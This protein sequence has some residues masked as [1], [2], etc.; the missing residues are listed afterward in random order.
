MTSGANHPHWWDPYSN[1]PYRLSGKRKPR[2]SA[3]SLAEYLKVAGTALAVS[4]RLLWRYATA[5]AAPTDRPAP[6]FIGLSISPDERHSDEIRGMVDELGVEELLIRIPSWDLDRVDEYV[7][8]AS[9]FRD[10]RLLFNILQCRESVMQPGA[11]AAALETI[12]TRFGHL[13]GYFQIG[14]AVNRTKWGC[15]HSGEYLALLEAAERV[16]AAHPGVRLVGSSVIDF[17]PLVTLRTLLNA[18]R[19]HL[20]VVSS[21]MYVN[22]R[23][24]PRGRQYLVFDLLRKLRLLHAI[25]S[26]GNRN[27]RRLWITE[28]NWPLLNTK[29]YTPNSGHP[30]R[31]VDE[32]TQAA[33]MTDYYRIAWQ[34]GWVEKVYWWELISPGYGLVD[35]RDGVL[36][37]LP[38]YYAFKALLEGGL[39][40]PPSAAP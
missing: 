20:D 11:W 2:R 4:P 36:R 37:K 21:L 9:R 28:F 27:D 33:Y 26:I 30:D 5:R 14:N 39:Y 13:S 40:E 3:A 29:P 16:R 38:S 8:F 7:D 25:A 1:Q 34:S 23:G 17:E 35:H 12:F 22:R 15:K 10:H 6:A 31:T 24:S 19:Y 32:E 18:R